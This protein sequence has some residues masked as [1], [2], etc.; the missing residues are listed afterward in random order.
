MLAHVHVSGGIN[1]YFA[2][3]YSYLYFVQTNLKNNL[4]LQFPD[5]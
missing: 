5:N 1:L 3:C 4:N 2:Y